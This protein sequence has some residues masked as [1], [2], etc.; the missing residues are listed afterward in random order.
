VFQRARLSNIATTPR[1]LTGLAT[2]F[3]L[4]R[5]CS[6]TVSPVKIVPFAQERWQCKYENKVEYNLSESSVQPLTSR[7]LVETDQAEKALMA[8]PLGYSQADGTQQLKSAIATIYKKATPE[9]IMVTTGSSEANFMAAWHLFEKGDEIVLMAPDYAQVWGLAKTF[10][11]KIKPLW[12]KEELGWQFDL[13]D[14]KSLVTNKSKVIQVCNPNNP[15]GAVMAR[16]QRKAI[17]DAARDSSA[18]LMSDEIFLGAEREGPTTESLWGHH[19]RTLIT[20][21]LSKAYGLNGLRIGWLVGLPEILEEIKAHHDYT[22]LAPPTLSDHLAQLALEP[23]KREKILARTRAILQ[24]NYPVLRSWLEAHGSLFSHVPPTACAI[25]Y[26]KYKMK[27]NSSNLA[28]RLR[29]EKSVLIVPGDHFM[30]DGYMRIGTGP[31][32]DYL[33]NGLERVDELLRELDKDKEN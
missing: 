3:I 30:M 23:R 33:L 26:I 5:A 11:L 19:D 7:E 24:K 17:L 13:E 27:I 21:G 10:G 16:E 20:G 31:P 12:L 14:L 9:N 18:W 25:C 2:S 6:R 4:W 1:T 15:T 29:K 32:T 28:E 8:I 22:T